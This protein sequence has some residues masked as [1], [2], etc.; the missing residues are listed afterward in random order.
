MKKEDLYKI[1]LEE[2]PSIN[3]LRNEESLFKL[4]PELKTCKGFNQN[5]V[6]HIYDVYNHILHVVDET[7]S[8]LDLRLAALFHDIG[9]PKTY[10][11]DENGEGHFFG[12]W[13][14]SIE[15]FKDFAKKNNVEE[16]LK[17]KVI[18]LIYYHDIRI[19]KLSKDEII[20]IRKELDDEEITKLY[21]LKKADLLAQNQKYH[22]MIEDLTKEEIMLKEII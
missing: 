12:H 10:T 6:W 14:E 19:N 22:Y 7:D 1:L 16:A 5:S 21:S 4:I 17:E 8:S 18:K 9:K 3:L 15:I 2:R 13:N 20:K 11:I